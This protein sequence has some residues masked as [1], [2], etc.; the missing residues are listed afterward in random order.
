MKPIKFEE[1]NFNSQRYQFT[2]RVALN[3]HEVEFLKIK[4]QSDRVHSS[5]NSK[6][7]LRLNRYLLWQLEL[8]SR[9]S[10]EK[11]I[12]NNRTYGDIL[13]NLLKHVYY[14]ETLSIEE[15]TLLLPKK[16]LNKLY[17]LDGNDS[18]SYQV[19]TLPALTWDKDYI[20][21]T[22]K[23]AIFDPHLLS[24][25]E[26]NLLKTILMNGW[27]VNNSFKFRG[28][29]GLIKFKDAQVNRE[30][31][32]I[33]KTDVE[34]NWYEIFNYFGYCSGE[35]FIQGQMNAILKSVEKGIKP[36]PEGWRSDLKPTSKPSMPELLEWEAIEDTDLK[37][38]YMEDYFAWMHKEWLEWHCKEGHGNF[39]NEF[40]SAVALSEK[41][42]DFVT[43]Y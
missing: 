26:K 36:I 37:Q 41:Q 19:A 18:Y 15:D 1:I 30:M 24:V 21:R 27:F 29:A 40:R 20:L 12:P 43:Y 13:S 5:I 16:Y 14:P 11:R 7:S 35:T 8:I 42:G 34:F 23:L 25:F 17:Y 9:I 38:K 4:T 10:T 32:D 28:L 2:N 22:I 6:T 3:S 33:L 31:I 39:E